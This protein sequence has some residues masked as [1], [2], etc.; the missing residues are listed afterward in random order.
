MLEVESAQ[1]TNNNH[2]NDAEVVE[3]Y[4][5]RPGPYRAS[6]R[7]HSTTCRTCNKEIMV[8]FKPKTNK[9]IYCQDCYQ[10]I[11]K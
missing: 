3:R 8:P 2:D 7:M 10:K 9:P 4:G 1:V 5:D 11:E 6:K